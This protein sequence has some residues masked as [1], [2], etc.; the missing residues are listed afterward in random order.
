MNTYARTYTRGINADLVAAGAVVYPTKVAMDLAA[1]AVADHILGGID[2]H[3][4]KDGVPTKLASACV[5]A[6]AVI[7]DDMC[8]DA[9]GHAPELTKAASAA[10]GLEVARYEA[11]EMLKVA[12]AARNPVETQTPASTGTEKNPMD[13]NSAPNASATGV[14]VDAPAKQDG[15]DGVPSAAV[16]GEEHAVGGHGTTPSNGDHAK[17]ASF[18]RRITAKIAATAENPMSVEAS[19]KTEQSATGEPSKIVPKKDGADGVPAS[20]VEGDEMAAKTASYVAR[21]EKTASAALPYLPGDL[22]EYALLAHVRAL[23]KLGSADDQGK[24]LYLMYGAYGM[25]DA[26]AL[27]YAGEYVK[28]ASDMGMDEDSD[29][30]DKDKDDADDTDD[31]SSDSAIAAALDDAASEIEKS[32]DADDAMKTASA[33]SA[34]A[35]QA[36]LART[37]KPA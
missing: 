28:R 26:D 21:V 10:N 18:A 30:K 27:K 9:G 34:E 35:A 2:F 31:G 16:E 11:L 25:A 6:L 4:L 20:A 37:A 17:L 19:P 14:A 32:K 22:P 3:Q 29:D 24:Y 12:E 13:T 7:A 15:A 23:S 8:K 33:A 1:D 5:D 36:R